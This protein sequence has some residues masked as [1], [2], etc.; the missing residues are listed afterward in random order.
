MESF[1][2][3]YFIISMEIIG[4]QFIFNIAICG[5]MTESHTFIYEV[6]VLYI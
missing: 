6:P 2:S 1:Q 3:T 5:H 4:R